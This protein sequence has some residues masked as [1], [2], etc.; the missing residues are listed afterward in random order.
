MS[1]ATTIALPVLRGPV[2]LA[3][4]VAALDLL[5]QGRLIAG[6]G[7]G[8]SKS[9]YDSIES[10]AGVESHDVRGAGVDIEVATLSTESQRRGLAGSP[11]R[12]AN[13]AI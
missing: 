5:Y 12:L 6:V 3:K 9:D 10:H 11:F 2:P 1:L 7:P 8:S 4:A 13:P